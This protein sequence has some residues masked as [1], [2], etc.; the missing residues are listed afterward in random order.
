MS[1]AGSDLGEDQ[2]V[3]ARTDV[4]G[5]AWPT[6]A[7]ALTALAGPL[8]TP[9]TDL[10]EVAT[11]LGREVV[12]ISAGY[13]E[14]RGVV[15]GAAPAILRGRNGWVALS[16][17]GRWWAQILTPN[18]PRWISA[19]VLQRAV[20]GWMRR[21][22]EGRGIDGAIADALAVLPDRLARNARIREAFAERWA[23]GRKF[24]VGY[25][26][27]PHPA[28]A[29]VRSFAEVR[30]VRSTALML[31]AV[32]VRFG[33]MIGTWG[34]VG[35][36]ALSGQ[37]DLAAFLVWI[38]ILL[39]GIPLRALLASVQGE[40]GLGLGTL[41]QLR[42]FAG[43]VAISPDD[44]RKEGVGSVLGR[45]YEGRDW[46]RHVVAGVLAAGAL[47]GELA[48][49]A[50]ALG[51][52]AAGAR[53]VALLAAWVAAVA[54]VTGF[55]GYRA[56]SAAARAR[57][58]LT[59]A[60]AESMS[61]HRTRMVQEPAKDRHTSEDRALAAYA[62]LVQRRDGHM[63]TLTVVATHGWRLVALAAA[64]GPVI[65]GVDAASLALT[66]GGVLFADAAMASVLGAVASA[67]GATVAWSSIGH[68]YRAAPALPPQT[69]A[70]AHAPATIRLSRVGFRY[71]GSERWILRQADWV[72]A[73]GDRILLAG[74]S[75]S[76]KSTLAALL[77]GLRAPTEGTVLLDG[78]D[79]GS[80]G[81]RTWRRR[82]VCVPQFH[83]NHVL[84]NTYAFNVLIGEGWPP[85]A[86]DLERV[87]QVSVE[88]GLGPLLQAMPAGLAQMIGDGGWVM[89]HGERARLFL[90][91]ALIQRPAVL[92]VDESFGAMDP[93][94]LDQVLGCLERTSTALVVIA[95][96]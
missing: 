86:A 83:Q 55:V 25:V 17:S 96:P 49:A 40:L 52:G 24:D 84:A 45:V 33:V 36:A 18:G 21:P 79:L 70:P 34:I 76:G 35:R 93:I 60:L 69:P 41:L 16:R 64:A 65:R 46:Q 87:R 23:A 32:A 29:L 14:V 90:A 50:V 37:L 88:L 20:E 62:T 56:E 31:G 95:H 27:R 94:T 12:P 73:P 63:A 26:V 59:S 91:R 57:L 68:L 5:F 1:D 30:I 51:N 42:L 71:P 10:D 19:S 72:V 9:A 89:S 6:A 80:V 28:G 38:A 44:V 74:A 92:V 8:L 61:G 75:G 58:D 13:D 81:V 43:V 66:V 3:A 22:G 2:P 48:L 47:V 15:R 77:S 53:M 67:V 4:S 7:E 11:A 82:V 54:S 78:L 85:T 39:T